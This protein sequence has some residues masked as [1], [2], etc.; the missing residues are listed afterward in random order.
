MGELSGLYERISSKIIGQ[1]EA[2]SAVVRAVKRKRAG[3]S[4][5]VALTINHV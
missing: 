2:V 3:V 1:D 5:M 4:Y